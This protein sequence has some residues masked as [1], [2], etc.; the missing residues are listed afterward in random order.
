MLSVLF[1]PARQFNG[2]SPETTGRLTGGGFAP[3]IYLA[4]I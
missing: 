1:S 3:A 2:S 4:P